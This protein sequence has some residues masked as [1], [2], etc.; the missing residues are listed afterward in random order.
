VIYFGGNYMQTLEHFQLDK[1]TVGRL[2]AFGE[3]VREFR[4]AGPLDPVAA[5]KLH[6]YFRVLHIFHS[7]GIEGNR[8]SLQ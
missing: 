3:D 2:R 5:K 8:L 1:E 7:T 6:E 4:E